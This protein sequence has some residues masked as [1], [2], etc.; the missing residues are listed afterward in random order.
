M[1]R[2]IGDFW[3]GS[4]LGPSWLLWVHAAPVENHL[5]AGGHADSPVAGW[6]WWV[7]I[8][9]FSCSKNRMDIL[10]LKKH[11]NLLWWWWWSVQ[12]LFPLAHLLHHRSWSSGTFPQCLEQDWWEGEFA[13]PQLRLS[14]PPGP[15]VEEQRWERGGRRRCDWAATSCQGRM[16]RPAV[17]GGCHRRRLLKLLWRLLSEGQGSSLIIHGTW[18]A[19]WSFPVRDWLHSN[20]STLANSAHLV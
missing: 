17:A 5:G 18:L 19:V 20:L 11:L 14:Q 7:T 4:S 3:G 10:V 13:P 9:R 15:G 1:W 6:G 12:L 2:K 8:I 16:G